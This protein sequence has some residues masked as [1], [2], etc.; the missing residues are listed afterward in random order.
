M[1]KR[2]PHAPLAD[3]EIRDLL[4]ATLHGPLPVATM[5]RVFATIA[6]VPEMRAA[7]RELHRL[8]EA[9]NLLGKKELP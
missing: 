5:S 2:H 1:T 4:S 3:D 7:V 6:Q 8:R 9:I